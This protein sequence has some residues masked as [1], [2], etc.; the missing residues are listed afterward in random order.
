MLW[1]CQGDIRYRVICDR[2][3]FKHEIKEWEPIN[4]AKYHFKFFRDQSNQVYKAFIEEGN[5]A[6]GEKRIVAKFEKDIIETGPFAPRT[7]NLV[8]NWMM[9]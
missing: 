8:E 5:F 1:E 4:I 9:V 3:N 7:N 6:T 2:L